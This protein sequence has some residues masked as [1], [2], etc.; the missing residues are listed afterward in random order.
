MNSR[1]VCG[2]L[3]GFAALLPLATHA[4]VTLAGYWK[5]DES[6]GATS[7]VDSSGLDHLG[8]LVGSSPTFVGGV[9]GNALSL[10]A[11]N[12]DLANMGDIF[13]WVGTDFSVSFWM[14]TTQ[15]G[16]YS[17]VSR[18]RAAT[19]AGWIFSVGASAGYGADS[20]VW[21]NASGPSG[22]TSPTSSTSVNDGS[23]YHVVGIKTGANNYLYVNGV[24]EAVTGTDSVGSVPVSFLVGGEHNSSGTATAFYTGQVDDLQVYTGALSASDI[25]FLFTNPGSAIPE[26]STYAALAGLA[27]LG[28]ALT[29]RFRR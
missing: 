21:L 7:V 22:A 24:L 29:Q 26:P 19:V 11:A 16:A 20:K 25:S 23:W 15:G 10:T 18:H 4:Q 5:F 12:G 14:K 28:W 27:A 17:I 8:T 2:C 9:A 3:F 1:H 13:S 6:T